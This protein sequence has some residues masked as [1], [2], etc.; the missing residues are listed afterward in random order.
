MI[1]GS[2]AQESTVAYMLEQMT[3]KIGNKAMAEKLIPNFAVGCRGLTVRYSP[4]RLLSLPILFYATVRFPNTIT[5]SL[6]PRELAFVTKPA[7]VLTG[8]TDRQSEV[9]SRKTRPKWNRWGIKSPFEP[10]LCEMA[11]NGVRIEH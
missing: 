2:V 4:Y 7:N 3:Q 5:S 10:F 8:Y 9:S 1:N 6:A 11:L